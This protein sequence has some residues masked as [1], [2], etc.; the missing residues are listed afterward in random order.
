MVNHELLSKRLQSICDFSGLLL[1]S[2][3]DPALLHRKNILI[4]IATSKVVT[5][6]RHAFLG[7]G[8]LLL[9]VLSLPFAGLMLLELI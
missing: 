1:Q 8:D 9:R 6:A 7:R 3:S 2:V 5:I 4:D